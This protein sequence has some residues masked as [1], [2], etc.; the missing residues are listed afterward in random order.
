MNTTSTSILVN[1]TTTTTTLPT[2]NTT[3][4]A[5]VFWVFNANNIANFVVT[6]L[7]LFFLGNLLIF[8][9]WFIIPRE[10]G[11]MIRWRQLSRQQANAFD[12]LVKMEKGDTIHSDS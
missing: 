7:I 11:D 6:G 10:A 2:V 3:T 8:I 5:N 9:I 12:D 1:T 4:I